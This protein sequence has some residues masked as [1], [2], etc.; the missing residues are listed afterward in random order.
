ML[1][2]QPA[3]V[4]REVRWSFWVLRV[5]D[6]CLTCA[7]VIATTWLHNSIHRNT[8]LATCLTPWLWDRHYFGN[9]MNVCCSWTFRRSSA[10]N[11]HCSASCCLPPRILHCTD[12]VVGQSWFVQGNIMCFLYIFFLMGKC[13]F[14]W[15]FFRRQNPTKP[16]HC[17][18]VFCYSATNGKNKAES[19]PLVYSDLHYLDLSLSAI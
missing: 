14:I 9:V 11:R 10:P 12:W 1:R 16:W 18:I 15:R 8:S 13:K 19:K 7:A 17:S 4:R 6:I 5:I 2:S 3:C